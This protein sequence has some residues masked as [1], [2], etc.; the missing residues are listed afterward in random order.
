MPK[1]DL[2]RLKGRFHLLHFLQKT[3]PLN[4]LEQITTLFAG[5]ERPVPPVNGHCVCPAT[6]TWAFVEE[7]SPGGRDID[8]AQASLCADT[9]RGSSPRWEPNTR[10]LRE[11]LPL[12]PTPMHC[13]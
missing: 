3:L 6:D 10:S 5:P 13:L 2:E 7:R 1:K 11:G 4:C 9:L 8:A 12:N